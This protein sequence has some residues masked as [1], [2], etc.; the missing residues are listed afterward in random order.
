MKAKTKALTSGLSLAMALLLMAAG[1]AAQATRRAEMGVNLTF[2]VYQYDDARS[3]DLPDTVV[4]KQTTSSAEEEISY[5]SRT[6]GV[7]DMKARHVRSVGLREGEPFGDAQTI[8]DRELVLTIK[9]T[10]VSRDGVR[11]DVSATFDGKNLMDLKNVAVGNYETIM[12]KGGRGDFGVKEFMGPK[13]PENVPEKRSLLV[14]ITPTV[15]AVRGLTNR[16]SD[17]SKPVDIY[18][19]PVPLN[20]GDVFVMPVIITR[21]MPKFVVGTFPKGQ[22]ILEG[23]VTPD[24][25]VTNI[26]VIDTPDTAY[27]TKVIEA[28]KQY[29]FKPALL[30][31]KPTYASFRETFVFSK[32]GPM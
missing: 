6:Y 9:P 27:N 28:F 20:E 3:R 13:G 2:A 31:G 8:N 17:L 29:H 7:E 30:N 19:A 5:I 21:T 12:L 32:P 26:K 23:T 10:S 11:F 16:P 18:G 24:G 1:V 25:R 4:L 14:T 22:F 15:I